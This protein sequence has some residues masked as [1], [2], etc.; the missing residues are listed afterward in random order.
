MRN[1]ALTWALSLMLVTA[2]LF[3]PPFSG[4]DRVS[5]ALDQRPEESILFI[6]NGRISQNDMPTM[7]RR[8]A[9]SEGY[10]KKLRIAVHAPGDASMTEHAANPRVHELIAQGWDHVVLQAQSTEQIDKPNWGNWWPPT[11]DMIKEVQQSGATPW[12]LVTWRY[13]D[14]CVDDPNWTTIANDAMHTSIQ[15]QHAH[16]N[17]NTGVDLVNVGV[18]WDMLARKELDFPLYLD[19][20]RPSIYGSYLS[21]LMLYN[22]LLDG[23]LSALAYKPSGIASDHAAS[24]QA[25]VVRFIE[26]ANAPNVDRSGKGAVLCLWSIYV[27]IQHGVELCKLDA[28]HSD[29][30]LGRSIER[31]EKFTLENTTIGVSA[32]DLRDHKADVFNQTKSM[33]DAGQGDAVCRDITRFRD[34]LADGVREQTDALL[35]IPREPL[36]NPCL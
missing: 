22:K 34:S 13:A 11:T 8:L 6:G 15:Q 28:Q 24:L 4:V 1:P 12:M 32:G 36:W 10:E 19:C 5:Y 29:A 20:S 23:D 26:S 7:V 17:R 33:I 27:S 9:D 18:V 31:I 16:L 25:A 35:S 21:A 3:V 2:L 14:H 30:E